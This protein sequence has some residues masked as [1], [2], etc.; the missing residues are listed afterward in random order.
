[1]N[2]IARTNGTVMAILLA[3]GGR[4]KSGIHRVHDTTI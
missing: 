4:M 1:M 2:P 3:I